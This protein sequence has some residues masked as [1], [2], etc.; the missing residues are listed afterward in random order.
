MDE[1]EDQRSEDNYE[2]SAFHGLFSLPRLEGEI[3]DDRDNRPVILSG[4]TPKQVRA[5]FGYAYSSPLGLQYMRISSRAI[6]Q[7]IDTFKFA[8]KYHLEPFEKWAS[9]A[10]THICTQRDQLKTSGPELYMALLE[11]DLLCSLPSAG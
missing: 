10:I 5:F 6:D 9:Q 2:S 7:L 1:N 8:H 4:D 3:E 11:M